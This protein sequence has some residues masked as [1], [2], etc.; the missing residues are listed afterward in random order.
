MNPHVIVGAGPAGAAAARTLAERGHDVLL[1]G[2]EPEAP[3]DRTVLT[4]S[5]LVGDRIDLPSLWPEAPWRRAIDHRHTRVRALD[6]AARTVTTEGGQT[7]PY[8][9]CLLATGAAPRALLD[10]PDAHVVR[11][12]RDLRAL[13]ASLGQ[14]PRRVLVV[15]GGVIGLE[16]AASLRGLGHEVDV[17]EAGPRILGRGVPGAVAD[18]IHDLHEAHGVHVR[19]ASPGTSRPEGRPQ[20]RPEGRLGGE[21]PAYDVV[22]VGIGVTPRT[23]L[24]EAAGLACDDGIVTDASGRTSVEGVFAAG[25]CARWDGVRLESYIAAG[26]QGAVAGMVM[27]GAQASWPVLAS[28]W[29][30]QY[31]ATMQSVG[32]APT[33]AI[34]EVCRGTDFVLVLS[35][36]PGDPELL[37]AACGASRGLAIARPVRAAEQL[38]RAGGRLDRAA[39]TTVLRGGD[40]RAIA[41]HLRSA[42]QPQHLS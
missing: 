25:D 40:L 39:L 24:A 7:I 16:V 9:A 15:G 23:A 26:E 3:Y 38:L 19:V 22:V 30:D 10:F 1:L 6:P 17:V 14:T 20:G 29:S 4:K 21:R 2:D 27:A 41:T 13:R 11:T 31:D 8:A 5:A 37:V 35:F 28:N 33:G 32:T 36:A 12:V 34:E 42:A 18:W